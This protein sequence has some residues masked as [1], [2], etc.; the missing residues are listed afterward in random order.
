MRNA[1]VCVVRRGCSFICESV[2]GIGVMT[3]A[4]L[5]GFQCD[6][7]VEVEPLGFV[8]KAQAFFT[9]VLEH[10]IAGDDFADH[11]I[12]SQVCTIPSAQEPSGSR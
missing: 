7:A 10:A 3:H 11:G 4:Y 5:G 8:A 12:P 2:F 9:E 6:D 1:Y